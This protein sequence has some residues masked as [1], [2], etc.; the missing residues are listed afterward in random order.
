[1]K[2]KSVLAAATLAIALAFQSGAA[3]ACCGAVGA[4]GY[5]RAIWHGTDGSI[6][7]WKT[8]RNLNVVASQN[9]GPYPGWR[10]VGYTIIANNLY[11]LWKNDDGAATIWLLDSN[12]D[13][14]TSNGYGPEAGWL[15]GGLAVDGFGNL[16]LVWYTTENQVVVWLINEALQVIGSSQVFGPYFGW[17]F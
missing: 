4:D 7:I 15:P 3:S 2:F 6:S 13:V 1:M 16:R 14:V 9:Y 12:L 10:E 17:T 5:T 11:I 8:D